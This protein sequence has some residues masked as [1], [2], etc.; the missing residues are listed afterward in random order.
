MKAETKAKR[1]VT[2]SICGL[3]ILDESEIDGAQAPE[4]KAFNTRPLPGLP[5]NHVEVV[6]AVTGEVTPIRTTKKRTSL[7]ARAHIIKDKLKVTDEIWKGRL[8][9]SFGVDTSAKLTEAQLEQL[10]AA[11]EAAALKD[12]E[13]RAGAAQMAAE[14]TAEPMMSDVQ[15]GL[16]RGGLSDNGIDAD[17][18]LGWH[19][20]AEWK[21][22]TEKEAADMIDRMAAMLTNR[23]AKEG[24]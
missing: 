9:K 20:R 10:V 14:Q 4:D 22:V 16:I 13:A 24:Q 3:G 2:L 12:A 6:D 18:V 5:K 1:R 23:V 8:A 17:E 21:E 15:F 11:L 19:S 7:L